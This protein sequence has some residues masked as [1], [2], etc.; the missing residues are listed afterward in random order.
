[1][2]STTDGYRSQGSLITRE[3]PVADVSFAVHSEQAT[4]IK[5]DQGKLRWDLLPLRPVKLAVEVMTKNLDKYGEDNWQR[6]DRPVDRFYAA[7]MRHITAWRMGE[8]LDPETNLPHL[9][10]ALVCVL[11][12]VWHTERSKQL[13]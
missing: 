9:A 8:N 13:H 3:E 11:F 7:L 2:T 10:H 6:I 4:G 12:L 1:M 5:H